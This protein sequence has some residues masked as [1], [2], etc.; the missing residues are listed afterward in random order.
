MGELAQSMAAYDQAGKK[1]GEDENA[2][3][4]IQLF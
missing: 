2:E 4:Q 1:V 3:D